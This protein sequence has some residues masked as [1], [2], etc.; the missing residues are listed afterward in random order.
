MITA[1]EARSLMVF[2]N[3]QYVAKATAVLPKTL[4]K[5][6]KK[7][8]RAAQ[9][10][11]IGVRINIRHMFRSEQMLETLTSQVSQILIENG[12]T[13]TY[14][15]GYGYWEGDYSCYVT[16]DWEQDNEEDT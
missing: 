8:R 16:A 6:E 3:K 7:I 1:N 2:S 10:G 9:R 12:F 13:S 5:V 15:C 4:L 11:Q 14:L